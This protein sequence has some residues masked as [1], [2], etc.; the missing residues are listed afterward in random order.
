MKD[1]VRDP[2]DVLRTQAKKVNFP[3]TEDEKTAMTNMMAYLEISQDDEENEKY[4]LRPGVGLAAP[5]VGLSEQF[6]AILIPN[7]DL[8]ELSDDDFDQV[9]ESDLYTFKGVIINPVIIRQSVKQCALS[10]GEGCLSVDEDIAGYVHRANKITV[11]YQDE[12]GEKH[13]IKLEGYPAIVFQHEIDH[14]HGTLYYDH[15]N[16]NEP[17]QTVDNAKYIG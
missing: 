12:T 3:L 15:I 16:Q 13:E 1:I 9:P 6:S 8:D 4:G 5:Q 7:E 2:A 11:S 14:L 17:W 10:T